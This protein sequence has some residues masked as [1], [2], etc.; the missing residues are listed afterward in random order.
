MVIITIIAVR[1]IEIEMV[2]IITIK[3]ENGNKRDNVD[4]I[5]N[6]ADINKV[7]EQFR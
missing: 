3:Q 5:N 4:N 2:L 1:E 7:K 6:C